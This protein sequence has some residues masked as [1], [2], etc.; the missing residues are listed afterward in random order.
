MSNYEIIKIEGDYYVI[1][2][3]GKR[4]SIVKVKN[5]KKVEIQKDLEKE[6]SVIKKMIFNTKGRD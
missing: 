2:T 4:R 1:E 6:N 3:E 5:K